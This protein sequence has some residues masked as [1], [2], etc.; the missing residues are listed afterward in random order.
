MGAADIPACDLPAVSDLGLVVDGAPAEAVGTVD[1][2]VV[3]RAG[4]TAAIA[5]PGR[6][7]SVLAVNA[8]F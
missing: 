6:G 7:G 3:V 8:L 1:V 5:E 4:D 2:V